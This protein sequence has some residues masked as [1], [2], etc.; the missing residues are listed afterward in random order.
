MIGHQ[1]TTTDG[2]VIFTPWE[3]EFCQLS[4]DGK[5]DINCPNRI[6]QNTFILDPVED[7]SDQTEPM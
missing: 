2:R 1:I 5:H 6:I 4:T 3:C 7:Y